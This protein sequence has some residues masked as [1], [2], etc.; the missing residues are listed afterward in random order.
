[1]F[2][3]CKIKLYMCVVFQKMLLVSQKGTLQVFIVKCQSYR[4]K[5]GVPNHWTGLLDWATGLDYWTH[6][7]HPFM[8]YFYFKQTTGLKLCNLIYL[9]VTVICGY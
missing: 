7:P 5:A 3:F 2:N 6:R 8:C 1:M 9:K 4:Q